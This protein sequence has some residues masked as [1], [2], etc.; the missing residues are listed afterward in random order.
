MAFVLH[1]ALHWDDGLGRLRNIAWMG[2]ANAVAMPQ[3]AL[4]RWSW[5]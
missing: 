2:K 1:L 4:E 3:G 5:P